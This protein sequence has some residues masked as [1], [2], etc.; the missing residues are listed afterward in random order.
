MEIAG[1]VLAVLYL[2]L[3]IRQN[4]WCWPAGIGS[5]L[6]YL[7]VFYGAGLYMQSALQL[8]YVAMGA[9]GWWA[10][11]PA[12]GQAIGAATSAATGPPVLAIQRWPLRRHGLALVTIAGL[13][14]VS[15]W[16]LGHY[17]V[18]AAPYLDS[19]V[20]WSAVLTTW[21]VTRKVLENWLYWFV[22]DGVSLALALNQGLHL[23]AALFAL[24]LVLVVIG[25]RAWL[26]TWRRAAGPHP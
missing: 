13:S 15:G 1:V 5:A 12:T 16:Y 3:A 20:T 26:A 9:Y 19:F 2:L 7:F 6:L 24:Y 11:R 14:L 25:G 22:I 8:F 18:S 17:S 21:M 4:R 23:T 10:W